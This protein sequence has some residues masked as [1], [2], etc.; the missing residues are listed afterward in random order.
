MDSS[1]FKTKKKMSNDLHKMDSS[2]FKTKKKM[3][4]DDLA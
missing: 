2:N 4:N 1:N 3:G